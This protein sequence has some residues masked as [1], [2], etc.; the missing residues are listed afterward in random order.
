MTC[1]MAKDTKSKLHWNYFL[2]LEQD[3]ERVSRYVEFCESNLLVFSIELARILLAASSEV[4]V[5]AKRICE[6]VA[7]GTPSR[8]M[9]EYR[10]VMTK[11]AHRSDR[12]GVSLP[13]VSSMQVLVPR[14]GLTLTPWKSWADNKNPDWWQSYN[15]VKHERD[16]HFNQASLRN[17]LDAMGAL[18]IF[19]FCLY[20]FDVIKRTPHAF[21]AKT[22]TY[23]LKPDSSLL[24]FSE[25][26]YYSPVLRKTG[27]DEIFDGIDSASSSRQ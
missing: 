22:I 20:R 1:A 23:E 6:Q 11:A 7:P 17:S 24:R 18:L 16:E 21:T 19:N 3:L 9:N 5:L 26:C 25:G 8:N 10:S 4:D 14:Y 15:K 13:D 27:Y 12:T 2:A